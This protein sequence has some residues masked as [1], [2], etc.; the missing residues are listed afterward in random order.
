MKQ[1]IMTLISLV[2]AAFLVGCEGNGKITRQN[3]EK[4]KEGVT[5]AEVTDILGKPTGSETVAEF[6]GKKIEGK[7]W[8]VPGIKIIAAFSN[9]GKLSVKSIEIE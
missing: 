3:F 6:K 7:V 8:Q 1:I 5:E 4:I 2:I 9:D